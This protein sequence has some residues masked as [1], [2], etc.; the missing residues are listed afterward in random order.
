[1]EH[2]KRF[3]TSV[4]T[5]MCQDVCSLDESFVTESKIKLLFGLKIRG[6]MGSS[7]VIKNNNLPT[8]EWFVT[9]MNTFMT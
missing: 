3:F 7:E 9:T 4:N 2:T 8:A 6:H 1:M 5:L